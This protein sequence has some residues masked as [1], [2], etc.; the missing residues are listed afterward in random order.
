[1]PDRGQPARTTIG[2]KVR[3]RLWA[4]PRS[5]R[6]LDA[7]V[8]LLG[9]ARRIGWTASVRRGFPVD[10]SGD[11]IPWWTYP[12]I[13]W[14]AAVLRSGD[15]VFEYGCGHS[16]LWLAARVGSVGGV[17]HDPRWV[18]R[19]AAAA[20]ENVDVVCRPTRGDLADAPDGDRYVDAIDE[21]Q[22]RFDLVVVDGRARNA[23][24]VRAAER[25]A[26]D[27]AIV[28][29]NSERPE[30]RRGLEEMRRRG[31]ARLDLVGPVPGATNVGTTSVFLKITSRWLAPVDP[32]RSWGEEITDYG[33]V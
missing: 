21:I 6:E 25:T 10:A 32:P 2:Q 27:G 14:L 19:I 20:P 7:G 24:L 18:R 1:V 22:G 16:T 17:D 26:D 33:V 12:A 28:L 30:F 23:C 11:P 3:Y 8:L 5:G 31:F 9:T 13:E 15:R 29:D 4:L